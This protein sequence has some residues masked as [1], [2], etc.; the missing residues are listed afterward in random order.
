[1]PGYSHPSYPHQVCVYTRI[2]NLYISMYNCQYI[3]MRNYTV[4]VHQY[5]QRHGAC[6]VDCS[7]FTWNQGF[8]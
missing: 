2:A 5:S 1:M 7:A 8:F 6:L 3:S 4:P